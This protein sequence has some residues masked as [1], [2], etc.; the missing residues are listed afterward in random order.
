MLPTKHY[1][2]A[3]AINRCQTFPPFRFTPSC[4]NSRPFFRVSRVS[5]STRPPPL[6]PLL[7][8]TVNLARKPGCAFLPTFYDYLFTTLPFPHK[9]NAHFRIRAAV[10]LTGNR[11]VSS[12]LSHSPR[13]LRI[14]DA[15]LTIREIPRFFRFAGHVP[16]KASSLN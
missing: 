10:C 3:L 8:G 6:L 1:S 5:H 12:R 14:S 16:F 7:L 4:E 15:R 13:G 2:K 9:R 11:Y